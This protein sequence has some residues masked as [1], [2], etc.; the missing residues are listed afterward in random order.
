MDEVFRAVYLAV[1][2][3]ILEGSVWHRDV[4]SLLFADTPLMKDHYLPRISL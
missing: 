2:R 1:P 4:V 3:A